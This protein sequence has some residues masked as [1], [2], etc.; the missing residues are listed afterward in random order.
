MPLLLARGFCAGLRFRRGRLAF[1]RAGVAPGE[2]FEYYENMKITQ[3]VKALSALAQ[4]SRLEVFRLLV[5]AGLE[6]LPAGQIAEQLEIPPATMSFHL[7]E[8]TNAGL[9][10]QRRDGR[11]I[12][13][14]LNVE[15]MRSLFGY[16]MEECCQGRPELCQPDY[17]DAGCRDGKPKSGRKTRAASK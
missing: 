6:G 10:N 1:G 3:V 8:L 9:V 7:K 2:H 17:M 14:A 11:S 13:Y 4:E 16:L 15:A 12:I 5:G